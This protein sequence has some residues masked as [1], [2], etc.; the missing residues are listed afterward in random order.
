MLPFFHSVLDD[1]PSHPS[2]MSLWVASFV[3]PVLHISVVCWCYGAEHI[4]VAAFVVCLVL[5]F[6]SLLLP[7]TVASAPPGASVVVV[8]VMVMVMVTK[9]E[10]KEVAEAGE[11]RDVAVAA[12]VSLAVSM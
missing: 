6:C 9:K 12:A 4:F 8:V 1:C 5:Y 3:F 11:Q 2:S 7:H 10:A